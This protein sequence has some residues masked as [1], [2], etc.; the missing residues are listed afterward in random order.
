M[1]IQVVIRLDIKGEHDI[2]QNKRAMTECVYAYLTELIE[3]DSL[4]YEIST[5]IEE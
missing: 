2:T 3:D 5:C 1:L 4:E